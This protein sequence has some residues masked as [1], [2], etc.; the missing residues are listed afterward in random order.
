V[1]RRF[2]GKSCIAKFAGSITKLSGYPSCIYGTTTGGL[3][4]L[5]EALLDANNGTVYCA[6]PSGAFVQ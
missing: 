1:R 6:S 5:T 2:I 4:A 3:G